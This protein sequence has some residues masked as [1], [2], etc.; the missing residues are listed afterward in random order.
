MHRT[1]LV[2]CLTLCL[3]AGCR[4]Q[5]TPD[6]DSG[7]SAWMG[8]LTLQYSDADGEHEYPVDFG[9]RQKLADA[10]ARANW[11][12]RGGSLFLPYSS[13]Y[14]A[15]PKLTWGDGYKR[16]GIHIRNEA[17]VDTRVVWFRDW[18]CWVCTDSWLIEAVRS[19]IRTRLA[20]EGKPDPF[21]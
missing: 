6:T 17:T 8:H 21:K 15:P 12:Y 7:Y 14:F 16:E 19:A 2:V 9:A 18:D 3:L 5:Q 1:L 20:A 13:T 10:W 4:S 11:K